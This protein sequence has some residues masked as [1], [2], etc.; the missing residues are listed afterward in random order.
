MARRIRWLCCSISPA[1]PF[2]PSGK[3][4]AELPV[5]IWMAQC[6][7]TL[8]APSPAPT[9]KPHVAHTPSQTLV[10]A[11]MH[12]S[13]S[14]GRERGEVGLAERVASGWSR[15]LRRLAPT[16]SDPHF[17]RSVAVLGRS[18]GTPNPL[19]SSVRPLTVVQPHGVSVVEVAT[20]LRQQVQLPR[21]ALVGLS[22]QLSGIGIRLV[23]DRPRASA[24]HHPSAHAAPADTQPRHHP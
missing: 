23:P 17:L 8:S 6:A 5:Y 2:L 20:F 3:Y 9:A 4:L 7:L 11:R 21:S 14:S 1:L 10:P 16:V 13:T 12:G 19:I 18:G 15:L 24:T 22:V